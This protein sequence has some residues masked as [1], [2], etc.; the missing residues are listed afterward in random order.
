MKIRPAMKVRHGSP[1]HEYYVIEVDEKGTEVLLM[2]T[3]SKLYNNG[4]FYQ[5]HDDGKDKPFYPF[6]SKINECYIT[7][8]EA[9]DAND[10]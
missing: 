9:I 4:E 2:R 5:K 3:N 10:S 1:A 7:L 6:W 8:Q